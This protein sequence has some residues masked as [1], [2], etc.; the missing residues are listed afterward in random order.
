MSK[1]LKMDE[2]APRVRKGA[3]NIPA[4]SNDP[5]L[6]QLLS[7]QEKFDY[8]MASAHMT[9]EMARWYGMPKPPAPSI[10]YLGDFLV[11]E[12][13]EIPPLKSC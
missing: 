2:W 5:M 8:G 7:G 9:P 1:I 11:K 3:K 4:Q 12:S 13:D 10:A 6:D